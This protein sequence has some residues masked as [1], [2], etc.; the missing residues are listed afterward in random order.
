ML[1]I[2]RANGARKVTPWTLLGLLLVPVLLIGGLFAA[3]RPA[4]T[5]I[6][7]AVVNLDQAVTLNG[8]LAPLGRQLAA[9]VV[10]QKENINWTLADLPSA[11]EGLASGRYSAVVVIPKGFSKAATSFAS[12]A[13]DKAEQATIEIRVGA[14]SPVTDAVVGQQIGRAAADLTS[15]MLTENYLE[16]IYLGFNQ[17]GEQ[18]VTITDGAKELAKGAGA[19]RDGIGSAADGSHQLAE[20]LKKLSESVP[21]LAKG[22]S[23]LSTQG[24]T[25][26]DGVN[27]FADGSTAL[28]GGVGQ[29]GQGLRGAEQQIRETKAD[30]SAL[31]QLKEGAASVNAGASGLSGGVNQVSDLLSALASGNLSPQLQAQLGQMSQGGKCSADPKLCASLAEAGALFKALGSGNYQLP[32]QGVNNFQCPVT[33]PKVCALL[34]KSYFDGFKSGTS[35]AWAS[36]NTPDPTSGVSLVQGA[37]ALASGTSQLDGGVGKLATELPAQA[38]VQQKTLAD[39]LGQAAQGAETIVE[40]AKPLSEAATA[41]K[42]GGQQFRTG[43]TTL[44]DSVGQLPPGVA[45]LSEGATALS[46]GLD[47][48][49]DGLTKL[50]EG[51]DTFATKLSQG[52]EQVPHYTDQDRS[53]LKK[54]VTRPVTHDSSLLGVSLNPILAILLTL[55]LWLGAMACYLV[56]GAIPSRAVTSSRPTWQL[57]GSV[58]IPGL[59]WAVVQAVVLGGLAGFV[60]KLSPLLTV[61]LVG[62][63][64]LVGVTF[65]AVN[66]AAVAWLNGWGRLIFL[67]LAGLGVASGLTSGV[68][69]V[70]SA[71][72]ALSPV[73]PALEAIRGLGAGTSI[74]GEVGLLL[75][76]LCAGLVLGAVAIMRRRQLKTI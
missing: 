43:L 7:G 69:G 5:Q 6:Q 76:W 37:K 11:E 58:L 73:T 10:K 49:K 60:L 54:V 1:H 40:K 59:I 44:A 32:Q 18:F 16:N 66:Q 63:L 68:P 9:E 64:I 30:F 33:D 62:L 57:A 29:L 3:T 65:V 38:V 8:E 36:L 56:L 4:T 48:A 41:L 47:G 50:A 31:S 55:G 21:E 52:A 34:F 67:G 20:G 28:V 39:A 23:T 75:I 2:E 27:Q 15:T 12:N 74:A 61:G 17:V 25:Y 53:T 22:V 70:V 35:V 24:G 42:S 72:A 45:Q 13:A 71:L 26:I 19:A 46:T 14:N 51:T